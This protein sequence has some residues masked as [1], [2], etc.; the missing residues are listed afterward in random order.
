MCQTLTIPSLEEENNKRK[1]IVIHW[2]RND[3]ALFIY[4]VCRESSEYFTGIQ[5][6]FHRNF[7]DLY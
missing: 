1:K 4:Q 6:S 3:K 7:N 5:K 2:K